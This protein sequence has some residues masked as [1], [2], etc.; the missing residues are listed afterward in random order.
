[1]KNKI[2][3]LN[4]LIAFIATILGIFIGLKLDER[5]NNQETNK[6]LEA[7]E[8]LISK[9][10]QINI[11]NLDTLLNES[12]TLEKHLTFLIDKNINDE[13]IIMC[14]RNELD[15]I[16]DVPFSN[17][18]I[19]NI[20]KISDSEYKIYFAM[21]VFTFEAQSTV[22]AAFKNTDLINQLNA[23]RI[24]ELTGIY[25]DFENLQE[26]IE[27]N[28]LK[29]VHLINN[30]RTDEKLSKLSLRNYLINIKTLIHANNLSIDQQ[31]PKLKSEFG[32]EH[33]MKY[34]KISFDEVLKS[35]ETIK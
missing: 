2:D 7:F 12:Y 1:M 10:L 4:H 9:E 24:T 11:A 35:K 5:Q 22:W 30:R 8:N 18:F 21:S 32:K 6:K 27:D 23:H 34:P 14:S 3:W 25:K 28:K 15:S 13:N 19:V 26:K 20:E 31:L 17:P 29:L 16:N 33:N